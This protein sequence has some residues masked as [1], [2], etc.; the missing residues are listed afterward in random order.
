MKPEDSKLIEQF[1]DDQLSNQELARFSRRLKGDQAFRQALIDAYELRAMLDCLENKPCSKLAQK[2][3]KELETKN[4]LFSDSVIDQLARQR[5]KRNRAK[6]WLITSCIFSVAA[7]FIASFIALYLDSTEEPVRENPEM[8][9]I[10][11]IS[12]AKVIRN[13]KTI[14]LKEKDPVLRNDEFITDEES[15]LSLSFN[16]G[17]KI[18]L[19]N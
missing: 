7:I 1:L 16:D 12:G 5:S 8:G 15:P 18:E 2:V 19:I 6:H 17:S 13:G 14:L 3:I 4:K 9:W 11:N 10:S